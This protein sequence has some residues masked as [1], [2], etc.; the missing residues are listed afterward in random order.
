MRLNGARVLTSLAILAG[1]VVAAVPAFSQVKKPAS[2][3]QVLEVI[4]PSVTQ[5]S[6]SE[7]RAVLGRAKL[8]VGKIVPRAAITP[9]GA[10]VPRG[11]VVEQNPHPGARVPVGTDVTLFVST[12]QAPLT[13]VPDVTR[14]SEHAARTALRDARLNVG[15][16]VPRAAVAPGGSV[17]PQGTV[18]EQDPHP[19]AR[20]AVGTDVT[21]FVSTGQAPLTDVPDVTRRSETAARAALRD[22]RLSVGKIVPRAAVAPGGSV[23]SQGTVVEQNPHPGARVAVGTDVTLVVS[24]GVGA[25]APSGDSPKGQTS[26]PS[27]Q[28]LAASPQ[29]VNPA[30]RP[31]APRP[32]SETPLSSPTPATTPAADSQSESSAPPP[33]RPIIVVLSPDRTTVSTR[34]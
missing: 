32:K 9:G 12:G 16:I 6:E 26:P 11:T 30:S 7:A 34:E 14:R 13:D 22:A 28:P 1:F 4:V 20:V 3:P 27:N 18:V 23:V 5:R 21:L 19:G 17:V 15:Q 24:T 8:D 2:A 29:E 25:V 10:V 31:S 33:K